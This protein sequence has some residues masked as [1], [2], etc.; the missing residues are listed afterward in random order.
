[1]PPPPV[2]RPPKGVAAPCVSTRAPP[3]LTSGP[4]VGVRLWSCGTSFLGSGFAGVFGAGFAVFSASTISGFGSAGGASFFGFTFGGATAWIALSA[5]GFR[6]WIGPGAPASEIVITRALSGVLFQRLGRI[7]TAVSS[8]ACATSDSTTIREIVSASRRRSIRISV[9]TSICSARSRRARDEADLLDP[10]F[11]QL[12]HHVD[13]VLV[14]HR[15]VAADEQRLVLAVEHQLA[16]PLREDLDADVFIVDL[17]DAILREAR[18]HGD[19]HGLRGN[20]RRLLRL[21]E[22]HRHPLRHHR[23]RHHE[24]DEEHE[25][26]V[27]ER[28]DVDLGERGRDAHAA[29]P[30]SASRGSRWNGLDLW[31]RAQSPLGATGANGARV[32]GVLVLKVLKLQMLIVLRELSDARPTAPLAPTPLAPSAPAPAAPFCTISTLSTT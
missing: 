10:G 5:I 28:D 6:P 32:L 27:H 2:A 3:C 31:H 23:R 17:D 21:R 29:R 16:D 18:R 25:H 11:L 19:V 12:V 14:L 1:M 15:A 9:T 8:A 13:D 7:A 20:R 24:D 22:V 26:D 30:S 4:C